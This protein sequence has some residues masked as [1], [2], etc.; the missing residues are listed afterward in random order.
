M[1]IKHKPAQELIFMLQSVYG[2]CIK[3]F[4]FA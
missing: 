2:Y 4:E 3:K 1:N